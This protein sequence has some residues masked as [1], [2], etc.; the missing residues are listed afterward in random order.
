MDLVVSKL[1][2]WTVARAQ[3][4]IAGASEQEV[5]DG[6]LAGAPEGVH[7]LV[8]ARALPE[9]KHRKVLLELASWIRDKKL[10]P[11]FKELSRFELHTVRYVN[12]YYLMFA[13][14]VPMDVCAQFAVSFGVYVSEDLAAY[15]ALYDMMQSRPDRE[16]WMDE[17]HAMLSGRGVVVPWGKTVDRLEAFPSNHM[18]GHPLANVDVDGTPSSEMA[19]KCPP[20]KNPVACI[21]ERTHMA[22]RI[23]LV[24]GKYKFRSR[25]SIFVEELLKIRERASEMEPKVRAAY[26]RVATGD[27]D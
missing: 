15:A 19:A 14:S 20:G 5:V 4:Y 26:R 27:K 24:G 2:S 11:V 10:I 18:A 13:F 8:Y 7:P 25:A 17:A 6:L 3:A 21:R 16:V 1:F 12:P 9:L 22:N 23:V